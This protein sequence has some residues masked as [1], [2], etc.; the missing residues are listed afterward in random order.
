MGQVLITKSILTAIA[1]AIRGK[2]GSSDTYKP[3]EMATAISNLPAGGT[4]IEKSITENGT[5]NAS[6]D[7][8][9]GYSK[10][11]VNV[12]SSATGTKQIS[13]SA[14]GT[15]THDVASYASAE[16]SVSV[17]GNDTLAGYLQNTLTSYT[18]PDGPW[19]GSGLANAAALATLVFPSGQFAIPASFCVSSGIEHLHYTN[20]GNVG[21]SCFDACSSLLTAVIDGTESNIGQYGFRNCTSLIAVDNGN[22]NFYTQCFSGCSALKT[23]VL[24]KT[25]PI[26]LSNVNAFNGT[27]FASGGSGG[28]IYIPKSLYDHLGD[29][30]SNDYKAKS[31]WSTVNGYGTITWAKIEGSAYENYYVDGT[32]IPSA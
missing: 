3:D 14:N 7:S 11:V 21:Q 17:S 32:P 1:N 28:T 25:S 5:Y 29:G 4:L 8:A 10:V 12:P 19:R 24:R 9:N 31:G 30:T 22:K 23:I 2:N 6:S 18:L 15:T 27:P 13:I 16:I 20:C 26:S